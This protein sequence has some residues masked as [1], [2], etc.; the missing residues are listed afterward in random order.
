[1]KS[2][3]QPTSIYHGNREL[4]EIGKQYELP[5]IAD[6]NHGWGYCAK[7][8]VIVGTKTNCWSRSCSLSLLTLSGHY[9]VTDDF[10]TTTVLIFLQGKIVISIS[11]LKAIQQ[12]SAV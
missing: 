9:F 8:P 5:A 10:E 11:S 4:E 12:I 6:K 2:F 3:K 1:M 7:I